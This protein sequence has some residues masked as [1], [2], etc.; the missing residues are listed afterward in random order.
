MVSGVMIAIGG[1]W[2]WE[3]FIAPMIGRRQDTQ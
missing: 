3:D 2:L 1:Y